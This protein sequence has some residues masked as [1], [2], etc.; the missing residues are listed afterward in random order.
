MCDMIEYGNIPKHIKVYFER[1]A[2]MR[3]TEVVIIA[4]S[5]DGEEMGVKH[6]ITD[7]G[8][9]VRVGKEAT[10]TEGVDII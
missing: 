1:D 8:V 6:F 7:K 2:S 10:L 3:A 5:P 4:I 9:F